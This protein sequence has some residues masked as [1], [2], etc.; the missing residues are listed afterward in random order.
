MSS[1]DYSQFTE[2]ADL[3][4]FG[5]IIF[6]AIWVATITFAVIYFARRGRR[7]DLGSDHQPD[8][9]DCSEPS[10]SG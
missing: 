2:L 7:K 8:H 10:Q 5:E 6:S 3:P 9:N 4:A 1:I